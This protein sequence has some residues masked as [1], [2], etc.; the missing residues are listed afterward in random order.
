[1][2]MGWSYLIAGNAVDA[3]PGRDRFLAA[4]GVYLVGEEGI[5]QGLKPAFGAGEDVQAKAWTYHKGKNDSRS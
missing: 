5:S 2:M 1:M 3:A 4:V